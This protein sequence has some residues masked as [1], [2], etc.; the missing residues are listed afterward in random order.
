MSEKEKD[1]VPGPDDPRLRKTEGDG[2]SEPQEPDAGS[3]SVPH[4]EPGGDVVP[5]RS[6]ADIELERG[7]DVTQELLGIDP[8]T[9]EFARAAA[10]F[11]PEDPR[12][13]PFE[14]RRY[15]DPEVDRKS[16]V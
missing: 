2:K 10:R 1:A 5:E 12:P 9:E 11:D 8:P 14:F 15:R 3:R 6:E 16:V 7:I 4:G 13:Q